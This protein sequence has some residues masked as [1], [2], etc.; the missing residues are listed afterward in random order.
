MRS[1]T[2]S[3]FPLRQAQR[4][5]ISPPGDSRTS[6]VSGSIMGRMP[7]SRMTVATHMVLEPDIAGYFVASMMTNAMS[8]SGFAVGRSTL[9]A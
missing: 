3:T 7:V 9:T 8:A 1:V 5:S 6:V 4:A 2:R